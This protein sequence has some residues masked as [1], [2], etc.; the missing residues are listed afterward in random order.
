MLACELTTWM[1]MLVL[2]DHDA[3]RWEPKRLRHR[4]FTVPATLA[5]TG[6]RILLHLT[7]RHPW[8]G[9]AP[10]QS[11]GCAG[12]LPRP[13][14]SRVM[15]IR[16]M[17]GRRSTKA[18]GST[19]SLC[20]YDI[21]GHMVK[22]D[23]AFVAFVQARSPALLKTAYL[24]TRDAQEAQDLV[25]TA[26]TNT[27]ASLWR[28]RAG[29]ALES[30]VRTSMVRTAVS[31]GR[32]RARRPQVLMADVPDRQCP[33]ASTGADDEL[34]HTALGQLPIRQRAVIVLRYFEDLSEAQTASALGCSTGSVKSQASRGVTRLRS[35]LSQGPQEAVEQKEHRA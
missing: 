30:Y 22:R 17:I 15:K 3:R 9:L 34:L 7:N 8:A 29:L 16:N 25:Q 23:D 28:L 19:S 11:P 4:L 26:L 14:P 20:E 33:P 1:Q 24:L 6:R 12:S 2:T 18:G 13:A 31:W 10:S 21:E 35:I 32:W 27:Y 5:R